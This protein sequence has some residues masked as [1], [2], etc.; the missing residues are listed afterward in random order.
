MLKNLFDTTFLHLKRAN[1][2]LYEIK[3]YQL[4]S[5]IYNDDDKVKTIDSFIY[6]YTK[7]QDFVADKLFRNLLSELGEYRDNM[8]FLDVLD[9]FEK[10]NLIKSADKW[11]EYRQLRNQLTHEYPD[12][13]SE[14]ISNIKLA[15]K[16]F[17]EINSDIENLRNFAE[18]KGLIK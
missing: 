2:A 10:L 14:I 1:T 15:I 12:N 11:L 3:K 7:L 4:D 9:K 18:E 8:S 13:Y 16:Y 5:E 6:R 17:S